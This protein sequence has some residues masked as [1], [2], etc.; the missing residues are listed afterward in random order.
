MLFVVILSALVVGGYADCMY[1]P[2]TPEIKDIQLMSKAGGN[3]PV[4][5]GGFQH[6]PLRVQYVRGEEKFV[7]Y[8][9]WTP[10][11][12]YSAA[13]CKGNTKCAP[14]NKW[15]WV[16]GHSDDTGL[17]KK[18]ENIDPKRRKYIALNIGIH[19]TKGSNGKY[20]WRLDCNNCCKE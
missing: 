19:H 12:G 1:T 9:I 6:T 5:I 13:K 2:G 10:P 8:N 11:A 14:L 20:V 3:W 4:K 18:G 17:G 16:E 7:L 15:F